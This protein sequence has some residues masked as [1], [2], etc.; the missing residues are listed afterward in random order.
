M[1]FEIELSE[2]EMY[3]IQETI[4]DKMISYENRKLEYKKGGFL[5]NHFCNMLDIRI[6]ECRRILRAILIARANSL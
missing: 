4:K 1:R 2:N 3:T 5:N 6:N